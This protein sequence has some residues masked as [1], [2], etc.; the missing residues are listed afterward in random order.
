MEHF[1]EGRNTLYATACREA[2]LLYR[3]FGRG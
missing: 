1:V 2:G 3:S